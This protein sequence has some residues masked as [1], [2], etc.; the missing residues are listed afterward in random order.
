MFDYYK[1]RFSFRLNFLLLPVPVN[2]VILL[3]MGNQRAGRLTLF[4]RRG[5]PPDER[6][7]GLP[8]FVTYAD[9]IQIGIFIVSFIGLCYTIFKG[10]K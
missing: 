7:E 3:V 9:L 1:R 4:Y 10:N 2:Y 8:M 6:K 5:Y